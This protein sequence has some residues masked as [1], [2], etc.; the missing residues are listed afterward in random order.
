MIKRKQIVFESAQSEIVEIMRFDLD[1]III[2]IIRRRI[3]VMGMQSLQLTRAKLREI[4]SIHVLLLSKLCD[5]RIAIV[6][7]K[8]NLRRQDSS[9]WVGS[10]SWRKLDEKKRQPKMRL[11]GISRGQFW[12]ADEHSITDTSS[13]WGRAKR[14]VTALKITRKRKSF[15]ILESKIS[16]LSRGWNLFVGERN[17]VDVDVF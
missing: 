12:R 17:L 8:S 2:R 3:V 15:E 11:K 13:I 6:S 7:E 16:A 5:S 14:S 10:N 9:N 4:M 1:F